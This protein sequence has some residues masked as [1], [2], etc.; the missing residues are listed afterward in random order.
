MY[1]F[2]IGPVKQNI[3]HKIVLCFFIIEWF[4]HVVLGVEYSQHMFWLR[5]KKNKFR[6][7]SHI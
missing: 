6:F 4:K 3:E 1:A 7:Y 5:I 2:I